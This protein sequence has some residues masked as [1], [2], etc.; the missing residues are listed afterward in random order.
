MESI[1]QVLGNKD[2]SW[3]S[4]VAAL[5]ELRAVIQ[6]ES[7]DYQTFLS[8]LRNME[9]PLRESLKDLRS[10]VVREACVTLSCIAVHLKGELTLFVEQLIPNLISLLPN[11]AKVMASSAS[12]CMKIIIEVIDMIF[13]VIIIVC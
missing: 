10:Q 7:I 6:C 4:R 5:K 8:L 12:L 3:D 13:L 1:T 9:L 2:N 11:S